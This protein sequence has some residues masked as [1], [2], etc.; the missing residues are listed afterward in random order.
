MHRGDQ[1]N[2]REEGKEVRREAHE[3]LDSLTAEQLIIAGRQCAIEAD[4]L[5][6]ESV[7]CEKTDYLMAFFYMEYPKKDGLKNLEPLF[8]EIE[9]KTQ[10]NFWRASL[11]DFLGHQRRTKLLTDKQL[12]T[13]V[14][15]ICTV[16]VEKTEHY[17]LRFEASQTIRHI[18]RTLERRNSSSD[19]DARIKT[20]GYYEQYAQKLLEVFQESSIN[21]TLRKEVL[22]GLCLCL[23][24]PVESN[25]QIYSVLENAVRNYQNYDE[26]NWRHLASIGMN[27]IRLP[28]ANSIAASMIDE[29]RNRFDAE[30]DKQKK[31]HL[32]T[33]LDS[34]KWITKEYKKKIEKEG[35]KPWVAPKPLS[36]P[37]SKSQTQPTVTEPVDV[38][39]R[40]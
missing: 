35:F 7:F 15:K 40:P 1:A 10:T 3:Y 34:L 9:D 12:Y 2:T 27:T 13:V 20:L 23:G 22:G 31:F 24:K 29:I 25:T 32:R 6:P 37:E 5:C 16:L 28:D 4:K 36:Q 26:S 17:G 19:Y 33:N 14:D 18:L 39:M 30:E 21:P 8:K 38:N 11:I